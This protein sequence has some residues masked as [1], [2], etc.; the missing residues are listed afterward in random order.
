M[1]T[2]LEDVVE[3]C[4]H[5]LAEATQRSES[6]LAAEAIRVHVEHDEWQNGQIQSGLKEA[7]ACDV[8]RDFAGDKTWTC[9]LPQATRARRSIPRTCRSAHRRRT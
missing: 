6:F 3:R 8:T 7:D 1:T 5:V 2:R 9:C 4:P